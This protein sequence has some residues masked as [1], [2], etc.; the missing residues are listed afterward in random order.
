MG[1][2]KTS[3]IWKTSDRRAKTV[4]NLGLMGNDSTDTVEGTIDLVA[5]NVFLSSFCALSIF[6]NLGLMIRMKEN[7]LSLYNI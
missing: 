5:F 4:L 7:V 1:K 6:L 2:S 3:I